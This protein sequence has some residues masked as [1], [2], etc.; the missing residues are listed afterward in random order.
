MWE[1]QPCVERRMQGGADAEAAEA[2][3]M[4]GVGGSVHSRAMLTGLANEGFTGTLL[5]CR[6]LTGVNT[7]QHDKLK[8]TH[9]CSLPR[10][11][12]ALRLGNGFNTP[13]RA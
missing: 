5:C 1:V 9:A 10:R 12:P 2:A 4:R 6:A 3:R 8:A 13:K 7:H 11:A